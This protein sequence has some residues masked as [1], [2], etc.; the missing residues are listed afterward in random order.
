MIRVILRRNPKDLT[1]SHDPRVTD[2]GQ[3]INLVGCKISKRISTH[4]ILHPLSP[5]LTFIVTKYSDPITGA[6][7]NNPRD[8]LK[9]KPPIFL[10]VCVCVFSSHITII[11]ALTVPSPP[12]H[13]LIS[14]LIR[15]FL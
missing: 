8:F 15:G 6:K 11:R 3:R 13:S 7:P 10:S 4:L 14:Q 5:I 12:S 9:G 1:V 2:L